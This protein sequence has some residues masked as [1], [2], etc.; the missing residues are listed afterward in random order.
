MSAALI[1]SETSLLGFVGGTIPL[2][3]HGLPSVH[4]HICIQVPSSYKDISHI[5]LGHPKDLILTYLFKNLSPN[6]VKF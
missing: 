4:T 2:S 3:S 1:S 6:M 5:G